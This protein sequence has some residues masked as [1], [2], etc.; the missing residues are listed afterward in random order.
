[1]LPLESMPRMPVLSHGR[2]NTALL[3]TSSVP[4][5]HTLERANPAM[6]PVVALPIDQL[7]ALMGH[8]SRM[9]LDV[10][11][12]RVA[13][14]NR[15][16]AAE[17]DGL[18]PAYIA[19]LLEQVEAIKK[20]EHGIENQLGKLA[21]GH[22]MRDVILDTPGISLAGFARLLGIT[23][24]LSNFATV[25]K[26]WKYLGMSVVDGHAPKR[27]RGKPF[28]KQ[29]D[30]PDGIGTAYS[31]QGRVLCYQ[32]AEAIVKLNRGPYRECY[33]RK[34]AEYLA[35]ERIGE[36]ECPFGQLHLGTDKK[37][38]KC[39][40]GHAHNAAM[41]YAV[42]MMLKDLWIEWHQRDRLE[43]DA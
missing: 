14:G 8:T 42:K 7:H 38:I 21:K 22:F 1:M 20:A 24:P 9:L 40:L 18:P 25:S 41:R 28:V 5:P 27:E 32:I 6:T 36:S 3:P 19:P 30:A 33:D 23:G 12:L 17:R 43:V 16:G 29:A 35:R 39:G 31:P 4:V 2:A 34:K 13:I 37:P 26:L 15:I 10:Q 11:K